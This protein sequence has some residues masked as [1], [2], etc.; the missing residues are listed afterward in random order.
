[1][2]SRVL[3]G[4]LNWGL[5]HASR[6]TPVI[7][8]LINNGHTL[9]IASS[10]AALELLRKNFPSQ[11]FIE[12][13]D[14]DVQYQKNE[15]FAGIGFMLKAGVSFRGFNKM[16]TACRSTVKE[17]VIK[18]NI[19]HIISDN[20]FGIYN[21]NIPSAVVCHQLHL[22][23]SLFGKSINKVNTNF[24]DEFD[25]IWVPDYS[26]GNGLSGE[27]SSNPNLAAKTKT[28]GLISQID[29][30]KDRDTVD[31]CVLLSGPEP[32]RTYL[33]ERIHN[34]ISKHKAYLK[35]RFE[36]IHFIEGCDHIKAKTDDF[37]TH[38]GLVNRDKVQEILSRAK[39]VICRSGYST[40]M[41]LYL[42][43]IPALIIPT[44]GQPEQ[45]YLAKFNSGKNNFESQTQQK[46]DI[47]MALENFHVRDSSP[48]SSKFTRDTLE[49]V[50]QNFLG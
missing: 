3:Y 27:L 43:D 31:L 50:L 25:E 47:R 16:I 29:I 33:S 6:S 41:D 30:S 15:Q 4:V 22:K 20:H 23:S 7:Q 40:L 17:V 5:G 12:L 37:V 39:F 44:P 11:S 21:P 1:M 32:Q 13:P 28:I 36:R 9:I 26:V 35:T 48:K 42:S 24:L 38:Y 2:S 18:E 10:G 19:T 34:Q 49:M 46:I 14:F 45:Q 8:S